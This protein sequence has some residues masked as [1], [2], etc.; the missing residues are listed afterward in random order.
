M[1]NAFAAHQISTI[2]MMPTKAGYEQSFLIG[3]DLIIRR[4]F[5]CIK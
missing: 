5:C 4:C 1:R 2:E 3:D